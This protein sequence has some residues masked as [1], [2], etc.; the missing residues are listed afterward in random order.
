MLIM[1][2]SWLKTARNSTAG[3][4]CSEQLLHLVDAR[5]LASLQQA[6]LKPLVGSFG[7]LVGWFVR[8]FVRS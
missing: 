5:N 3:R 7:W 8:S 4:K 1:T 2:V 6:E